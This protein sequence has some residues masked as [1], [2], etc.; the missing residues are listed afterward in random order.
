MKTIEEAEVRIF[1]IMGTGFCV[2]PEDGEKVF[3]ILKQILE[4]GNKAVLSFLNVEILTAAFLNT[5]IG[6]LYGVFNYGKIKE[7]LKVKNISTEDKFLLKK[8]TGTAKAY[9]K[10]NN[11]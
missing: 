10:K 3:R 5:A 8:V 4:Q 6:R 1:A 2:E 11:Q 9:Y 7:S